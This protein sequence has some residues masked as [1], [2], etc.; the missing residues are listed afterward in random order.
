MEEEI[1]KAINELE[2]DTALPG[3]FNFVHRAYFERIAYNK[4]K[5][6]AF[7]EKSSRAALIRDLTSRGIREYEKEHGNLV[8]LAREALKK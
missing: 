3:R 5:L 6:L 2:R 7:V 4:L 8:E 1:K